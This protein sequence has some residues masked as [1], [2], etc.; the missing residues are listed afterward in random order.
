MRSFK[1]FLGIILL[2][3][4]IFSACN[5][6]ISD[7]QTPVSNEPKSLAKQPSD[8]VNIARA[9]NGN[10]GQGSIFLDPQSY[11]LWLWRL[12]HEGH[13]MGTG[14]FWGTTLPILF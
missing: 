10:N 1:L 3:I 11:L 7:P 4:F 6:N 2:S 14:M 13:S 8:F 5:E 12:C 9:I